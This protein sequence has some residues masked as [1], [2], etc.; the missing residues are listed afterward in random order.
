MRQPVICE[1]TT[2]ASIFESR[3]LSFPS[4][5]SGLGSSARAQSAWEK[6]AVRGEN[7]SD[8]KLQKV[9]RFRQ[10][11]K[12]I[13]TSLVWK[14]RRSV[15]KKNLNSLG[16]H[17]AHQSFSWV[18][19]NLRVTFPA[20][21]P[22]FTFPST[23]NEKRQT[24]TTVSV[25]RSPILRPLSS[26]HWG[27]QPANNKNPSQSVLFKLYKKVLGGFGGWERKCAEVNNYFTWA[28]LFVRGQ[29]DQLAA[30]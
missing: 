1:N 4:R 13:W 25:S 5:L 19:S 17:L 16:R 26:T 23:T 8:G 9:Q 30:S 10:R 11:R 7:D 6:P 24:C 20:P 3:F 22:Y 15:M 18:W 2:S 27:A 12:L 14:L 29:L 21:F 28:G